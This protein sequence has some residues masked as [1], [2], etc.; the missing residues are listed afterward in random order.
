[1][2][3]VSLGF[4]IFF[5]HLEQLWSWQFSCICSRNEFIWLNELLPVNNSAPFIPVQT[6][7]RREKGCYLLSRMD[8]RTPDEKDWWPKVWLGHGVTVYLELARKGHRHGNSKRKR[9]PGK[10][11]WEQNQA[12]SQYRNRTERNCDCRD[13][14]KKILEGNHK[15]KS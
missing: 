15:V 3:T 8:G 7:E 1:M 6:G 11:A 5:L 10:L 12:I 14:E 2:T 9:E 13:K 4:H